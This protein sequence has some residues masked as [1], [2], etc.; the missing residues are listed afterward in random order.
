MCVYIHVG[1]RATD[2]LSLRPRDTAV[3]ASDK[4]QGLMGISIVSEEL[5]CKF[6]RKT[7]DALKIWLG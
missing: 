5:V 7:V 2:L 6:M 1:H 3:K 4:A